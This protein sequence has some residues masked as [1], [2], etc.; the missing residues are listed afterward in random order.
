MSVPLYRAF[1]YFG[2]AALPGALLYGFDHCEAASEGAIG[3]NIGLYLAWA[4][5]HL[6]MTSSW[7]KQ[8]VYGSP[9]GSI[10]ERQV[11]IAVTVTTWLAV[12]W[13]QHPVAGFT[14]APPEFIRFAGCVGFVLSVFAFFEGVTFAGLDNLLG[15]PGSTM[16]HSHGA[17]TPLF[18]EG[19]Y[20]SVRHPMYR[21][22]LLMGL[23]ALLI[24]PNAAQLLW[25]VLIGGTFLGFIPIEERQL[26][27]ARGDEYRDYMQKTP[28]RVFR[29]IW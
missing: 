17:E 11:Y 25:S 2:L 21:A 6:L 12:L 29:G 19:Q 27:R 8:T 16:S 24:H 28:W 26:L 1:S 13:L 20:A 14:Y 5:V 7:F 3:F 22:A 15:V 9:R 10:R 18:C 4:T 23:C